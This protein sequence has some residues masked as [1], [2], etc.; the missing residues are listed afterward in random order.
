MCILKDSVIEVEW[1]D[2]SFISDL[3]VEYILLED[4]Y[5]VFR[6]IYGFLCHGCDGFCL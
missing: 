5:L 6:F 2:V 4:R 1:K 3:R